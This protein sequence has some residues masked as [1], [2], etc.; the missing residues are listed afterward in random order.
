MNLEQDECENGYGRQ[1]DRLRDEWPGAHRGDKQM[2]ARDIETVDHAVG[3]DKA[4]EKSVRVAVENQLPGRH[5][6]KWHT[7]KVREYETGHR[8]HARKNGDAEDQIPEAR[9]K[10][11]DCD[12]TPELPTRGPIGA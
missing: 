9:I 5:E 4:P 10:K 8:R 12:E 11:A 1:A 7:E 2:V 6:I 3:D